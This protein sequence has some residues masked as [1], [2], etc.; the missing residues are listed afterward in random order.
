MLANQLAPAS[1]H[2]QVPCG[3]FDD[4]AKVNEM[5]QDTSTIKKAMNQI[6]ELNGKT[7]ALSMNQTVRAHLLVLVLSA[8]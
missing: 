1:V 2:C 7:D 3:I 5:M 6:N 4:P 8:C